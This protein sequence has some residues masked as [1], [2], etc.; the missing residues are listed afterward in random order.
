VLRVSI[1]SDLAPLLM[2][3]D[4]AA[5]GDALELLTVTVE[6]DMRPYVKHDTGRLEESARKN[7]DFRGGRI[8]YTAVD[9]ETGEDYAAAAYEDP[10]VG[11]HGDQNDKATAHWAEA[12]SN[13][14]SEEWAELLAQAMI[15]EMS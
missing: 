10:R 4:S 15:K 5:A 7:S 6:E 13:D 9:E 12:A 11:E 14:R 3:M 8:V 2:A 1:A